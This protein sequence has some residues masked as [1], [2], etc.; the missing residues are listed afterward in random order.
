[1]GRNRSGQGQP[2]MM[3][4]RL[5]DPTPRYARDA[6]QLLSDLD[7][8]GDLQLAIRALELLKAGHLSEAELVRLELEAG[9]RER[10]QLL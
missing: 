10:A 3:G 4:P 1:M 5:S 8:R 7:K 2:V 6:V 9:R